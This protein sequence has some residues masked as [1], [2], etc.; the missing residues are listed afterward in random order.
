MMLLPIVHQG[1]EEF[2]HFMGFFLFPAKLILHFLF[3][4]SYRTDGKVKANLSLI[5]NT[6]LLQ[7]PPVLQELGSLSKQE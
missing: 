3:Y 2:C 1:A 7:H 6:D 4:V 5:I